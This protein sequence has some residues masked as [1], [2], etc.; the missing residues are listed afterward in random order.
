M[1]YS[2]FAAKKHEKTLYASLETFSSQN[3]YF[4]NSQTTG[5]TQ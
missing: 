4:N 1:M 2:N 3:S 5:V